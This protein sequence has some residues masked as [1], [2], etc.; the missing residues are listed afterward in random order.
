MAV[1]A[2]EIF[3]RDAQRHEQR[4]QAVAALTAGEVPA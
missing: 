4:A 1:V 3:V 2:A